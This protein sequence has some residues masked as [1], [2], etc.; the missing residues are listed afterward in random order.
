[1]PSYETA[2]TVVAVPSPQPALVQP[3]APPS[4]GVALRRGIFGDH[5]PAIVALL[6]ALAVLINL[7]PHVLAGQMFGPSFPLFFDMIGTALAAFV[8]GPW[9]AAAVAAVTTLIGPPYLPFILVNVAGALAWGFGVRRFRMAR[10]LPSFVLLNGI[11]ALVCTTVAYL[12]ISAIYGGDTMMST[13]QAMVDTAVS[14]GTPAA[15]A[16]F[17]ANL[18]ISIADKMLAGFLALAVAATALRK[19]APPELRALTSPVA[20]FQARARSI[21]SELVAMLLA[22]FKQSVTA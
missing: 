10:S 15:L 12:V 17:A 6:F 13:S 5:K 8:L 11:V 4:R 20:S 1:M 22:Q 21:T 3:S 16:T 18:T 9:W 7:G 2:A 19:Y 14:Y